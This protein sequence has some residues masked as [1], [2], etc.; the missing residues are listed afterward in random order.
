[1]RALT[2]GLNRRLEAICT[3][4]RQSG[5]HRY[6]FVF[7]EEAHFYTSQDEILNLITRGSTT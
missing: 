3:E 6:P 4:E 7:F 5:Q 2:K 1:M